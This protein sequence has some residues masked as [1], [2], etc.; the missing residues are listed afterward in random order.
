MH[1]ENILTGYRK[2]RVDSRNQSNLIVMYLSN[3]NQN[4]FRQ[5]MSEYNANIQPDENYAES[6]HG[7]DYEDIFDDLN[8]SGDDEVNR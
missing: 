3:W 8:N 4:R 6:I 7:D 5:N 2:D 1:D